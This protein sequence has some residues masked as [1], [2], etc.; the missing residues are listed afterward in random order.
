MTILAHALSSKASRGR[1]RALPGAEG[2]TAPETLKQKDRAR[3]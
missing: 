3:R 1:D 2:E